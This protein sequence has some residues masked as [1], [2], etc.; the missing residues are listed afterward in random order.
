MH[1]DGIRPASTSAEVEQARLLDLTR[2][3]RRAGHVATGIDRV[4]LAYLDRFISDTVPAYGLMRSAFG[5]LLMD[6]DGMRA[7]R[8]RMAGTTNWGAPDVLSRLLR[9][10]DQALINAEA[11]AR[12]LA[13]AR[14][15]P[16]R[17]RQMLARHLSGGFDYF[18]VG[19]SNLT[20]RVLRSVSYAQGQ[21]HVLI[22][23]VIPL[24]HPDFQRPGT[25][26]PFREIV[27]RVARFADRVIYNSYDTRR[28]A[29]GQMREWGRVPPSIVAH[30]G[31]IRPR[32]DPSD[33]PLGVPPAEPYF[34]TVG[35]IE[36]RKNHAF[37]LDL[38]E[39][40]GQDAP[41]LF[42]CGS[43]GWNNDRVF[44]RLDALPTGSAITELQGLSDGALASLIQRS[45]GMLFPSFAEGYGLPPIEALMLGTRVLCNDL[46]VLQEVLDDFATFAPVS[47]TEIW[48]KTIK[49]WK[50]KASGAASTNGF[51][52][53]TWSDHFNTV[54]RLI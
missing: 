44:A 5:Y 23:D 33:L 25:V 18:N 49:N 31:T 52:G 38:W 2:S 53:P 27:Q 54:L 11:D 46:P 42:I 3:L 29:E 30:L 21:K 14:C 13:I 4:E 15:V 7:F 43:R 12:R 45:A 34:V 36:P 24:E 17:L 8:D 1:G 47:D 6:A 9:G 39:R 32:P 41:P 26:R 35:T 20:E 28:R 40:M 16:A 37:L 48:L 19:H 22:H 50:N 51:E 10:R